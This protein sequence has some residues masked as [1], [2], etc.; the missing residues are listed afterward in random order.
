M[1][2]RTLPGPQ[3]VIFAPPEAPGAPWDRKP[4]ANDGPL[5]QGFGVPQAWRQTPGS[6]KRAARSPLRAN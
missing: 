1:G 3:N 6:T 2:D 4:G 5:Q